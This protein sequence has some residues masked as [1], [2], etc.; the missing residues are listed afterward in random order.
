MG[1]RLIFGWYLAGMWQYM[2]PDIDIDIT[3]GITSSPYQAG[4]YQ[5]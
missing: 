3:F 4:I 1:P 5:C 2:L